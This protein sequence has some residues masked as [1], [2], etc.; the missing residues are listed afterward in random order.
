MSAG[1]SSAFTLATRTR[2]TYVRDTRS[3]TGETRR[4]GG[5]Q[6]AQKS[7]STKPRERSMASWN[8]A[9]V[10][11]ITSVMGRRISSG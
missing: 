11:V 8:V 10:R 7:T 4:H 9:S 1:L 5:Q 6:G 2:P 3:T